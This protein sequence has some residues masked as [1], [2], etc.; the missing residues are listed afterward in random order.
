MHTST[1]FPLLVVITAGIAVACQ[2]PINAALGRSVGSGLVAAGVSFAIGFLV[3]LLV[4][5]VLGLGGSIRAVPS[6]PPALLI[7]GAL[8]AFFVWTMLWSVPIMGVVTV[9]ATLILGQL[10]A[11]LVLDAIGAFGLPQQAITL[12]RVGAVALVAAGVVLSRL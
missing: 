6:A 3:L 12:Q 7:G 9:T 10:C 11:A 2:A 5:I 8:G 1:L 4:A